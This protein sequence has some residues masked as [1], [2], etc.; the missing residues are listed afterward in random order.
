MSFTARKRE[1]RRNKV[2]GGPGRKDPRS[3]KKRKRVDKRSKV[4]GGP[5]RKGRKD[6]RA[7]RH[8]GD[9]RAKSYADRRNKVHGGPGRKDPR[10][11]VNGGKGR[12]GRSGCPPRKRGR[13]KHD[14][15]GVIAVT[16][17]SIAVEDKQKNI[18][19]KDIE[20][21]IG[22]GETGGEAEV[23]GDAEAETGGAGEGE[24]D[25]EAA[26]LDEG[27]GEGGGEVSD[28]SQLNPDALIG[29]RI[30]RRFGHCGVFDGQILSHDV[31]MSGK[32][33]YRVQYVD[34]DEEDLFLT[35]LRPLIVC[36]FQ[37]Y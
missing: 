14:S 12:R 30:K 10:S 4:H 27:A 36:P 3:L 21:S 16:E 28:P 23:E 19:S 22:E 29:V 25:G 11:I 34:G 24:A 18:F 17:K 31:D 1:D 33:I 37:R 9:G 7:K 20:T 8:G 2:H 5:G 32:T 6:R 26:G 13:V 15:Q 35:E